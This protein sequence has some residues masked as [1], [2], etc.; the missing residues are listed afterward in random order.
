MW[1]VR[2][3]LTFLLS[4]PGIRSFEMLN[5]VSL[6]LLCISP[7]CW[8]ETDFPE[9][10][11]ETPINNVVQDP[12]TARMYVGAINA[13][14][15]LDG[16]LAKEQKLET[17][18]KKDLRSCTPPIHNNCP[19]AKDTNN[20]NK[21]LLV[22]PF[23]NSLIICGSLY[24]GICSL[25]NLSNI[26]QLIYYSES[27]SEQIYVASIEDSVS[28]VGIM[29]HLSTQDSNLTVFVVGKGYGS[30]DSSKLISTRILQNYREW[31]I[32]ESIIDASAV[33]AIPF[34]PK[35]LHDFRYTFK[36]QG[37][38]YFLF[39]RTMGGTDNKNFTFI[40]RLC[41]QDDHY[42]SYTELQ[43]NCGPDNHFNKVQA[44][45]V[46]S[47]GK[48][49]ARSMT[50]SV[51]YGSV[52]SWDRVLFV[53]ASPDDE[54]HTES[55][56]CLYPLKRINQR[57]EDIISACYSDSG[58]I[59]GKPAVDIPYS[60]KMDDLCNKREKNFAARYRCGAD[61]LPSP[62]ASKPEFA[63]K[64]EAMYTRK[65]LLTAVAIAVEHDHTIAFLGNSAGEVFKLHL[66][67]HPEVYSKGPG[68][69]TGDAVNK[70]LFFDSGMTHL[71]V[72]TKKK[73][74]KIPVQSCGLKTDC[75]S[76]VGL[77]DPYCG[78]CVLEGRCNRR[79]D[80]RRAEEK[81]GWLWSPKQ[82]C[83]KI[84]SFHPPNL[85]CKKTQQV[86]IHIPSL[87]SIGNADQ[88]QC[89]FGTFQSSAVMR[90]SMVTCT[91]PEPYAIP[92]TPAQQDFVA[93]PVKIFV[94]KTMEVVSSEYKFYNCAAAIHRS[95]N[96]PCTSCVSS[97]WGCQWN[98]SDHTCSD[99]SE[100]DT[101]PNIIRHRQAA[102]CP[103]FENP[104]PVLI[105]VGHKTQISFEGVELNPYQ[106]HEF[107]IGTELMDHNE[108]DIRIESGPF[109]SFSG[110]EYSYDKAPET[111]IIFYVKDKSS[112]KK[113]DSLLNIT[114]YNCSLG[115]EDC[116]LCRNAEPKYNCVWCAGKRACVYEKLC[117]TD[118]SQPCPNPKITE[119]EPSYGPIE[120]G[121]TVTIKGSNLG[122][123]N[124]DIKSITVAGV[125]CTHLGKHY[126]VSTS[127]V[128]EIGPVG[129]HGQLSGVVEV[130]VEGEKRGTSSVH[131]TYRD[132]KPTHVLPQRGPKAGGTVITIMGENLHTASKEDLTISVG[133]VPCIVE[134]FGTNI[135]CKTGEYHG[136]KVP[137]ALLPVT[138]KY[139]KHTTKEVPQAFQFLHNPVVIDHHP[140]KSFLCGGRRIVV[141]GVGFS[142]IQKAF[143][144]VNTSVDE[145]S[146]V[147]TPMEFQ[148]PADSKNDTTLVF[149]SPRVNKTHDTQSFCTFLHLDNVVEE[150]K[151][152]DY[153]PDP[154]FD[155]FSNK[156]IAANS[157]IKV[158][159]RGF[160]KAMTTDEAKAFV[161][162]VPCLVNTLE[163]DKLYLEPPS[164]RMRNVGTSE[165]LKLKIKFGNGEWVV[166]SVV[167]ESKYEVLPAFTIRT[168]II[169]LLLI[170]AILYCYRKKNQQT[171]QMYEKVIQQLELQ[172]LGTLPSK[173]FEDTSTTYVIMSYRR[174]A[175]R[176][177]YE[178][179]V[180]G[181]Q[182]SYQR[183]VSIERR[184]AFPRA[185]DNYDRGDVHEAHRYV[186]PRGY[187]ADDQR[188]YHSESMYYGT[189]RRN[190]PPQ[191][192]RDDFYSYYRGPRED[193][194]TV[195]QVEFS[196]SSRVA[197]SPEAWGPRPAHPRSMPTPKPC[198]EDDADRHAIIKGDDHEGPRRKGPAPPVRDRSPA[199]RDVSPAS[200]SRSGSS[201]SSRSYSPDVAKGYPHP[202]HH[203]KRYEEPH[204]SSRESAEREKPS[205][206]I[207]SAA[208]DGPPSSSALATQ[209]D[210][211][212]L[213]L[214]KD[215]SLKEDLLKATDDF[216]ER[217]AQA[218]AEKALEIEKLYRQDCETFGTVVK[219][220]VSKEPALE[221]QLQGPLKDSLEELRYRCLEDL[222]VFID[223]LDGVPPK[224]DPAT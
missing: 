143:I 71:Y 95:P 215:T 42:Y 101:G 20:T 37:F 140:K 13:V 34:V 199:K 12:R 124:N 127:V 32:F 145:R 105:T 17:G 91:L 125:P 130:L 201:I 180:F 57:I 82:Q 73:I 136:D 80:C 123:H 120:G 188:G 168:V 23:D 191:Y 99:M 59:D 202:G 106:N 114:L 45:Y 112:G 177:V 100:Q 224:Q 113:I 126:S 88:L 8:Q 1:M 46:A 68:D 209:G 49:L 194:P 122:I 48:E 182:A 78:W 4:T 83:V 54:D 69:T 222:R 141:T 24:R 77:K 173:S 15:Q 206:F 110:Y 139:G 183:V 157:T 118:D 103:R 178:Q 6:L 119:I 89:S 179:R 70:N 30:L 189:G 213:A 72:T 76:C 28:V 152:F 149:L 204:G 31:V 27:N 104:D 81:N 41:E 102:N 22:N 51:L 185:E 108:E 66:F 7:V 134:T 193:T 175:I 160:S 84:V 64:A 38:I 205:S 67:S 166:G 43:L 162:D 165:P 11:S 210:I 208:Q 90:D 18:P 155:H 75:Q 142:L 92:P 39:S 163:D 187:P 9:F 5:K 156:M 107:V 10:T 109:Y 131:F 159:G 161:G 16:L 211:P 21:L 203:K 60:S 40:S 29:S 2:H 221:K 25:V 128:C 36:D 171:K 61:F 170:I 86:D 3:Q 133:N 219:I 214:E 87:P 33:Q 146:Q 197:P 50:E 58:K 167:Y 26:N 144:K 47:P 116:S 52:L 172:N 14:Y 190:G 216:Q 153:H 137:S 186:G 96:T 132:P 147:S 94:N 129:P 158:T 65:G 85:S 148:Q 63:L 151:P 176:E 121:I 184:G 19:D 220:L 223:D 174:S 97:G 35:Y 44:A 56:L 192:K 169:V 198:A 53:V 150:L 111:T 79:S 195:R 74:I 200:H 138:V 93:V 196:G 218:I 135:T 115:R 117:S 98:T 55:A 164:V 154:T 207:T 181:Q 62:L 212:A 217:R